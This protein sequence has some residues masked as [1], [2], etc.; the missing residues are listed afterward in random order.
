MNEKS[1]SEKP[2]RTP[3]PWTHRRLRAGD[4]LW[5]VNYAGQ[6]T[7]LSD[8]KNLVTV[9]VALD[10][11]PPLATLS[12]G[13]TINANTLR[14]FI[15]R[16]VVEDFGKVKLNP[17]DPPE[18]WATRQE[19][20][21]IQDPVRCW[22]TKADWQEHVRTQRAW[23]KLASRILQQ[24]PDDMDLFTVDDIEAAELALFGSIQE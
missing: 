13:A 24:S 7:V 22:L 18:K 3:S 21:T 14:G 11:D 1:Q 2:S 16:K 15:T 12:N 5:C 6:N 4:T 19:T 20:V 17:H 8:E 10:Y 23:N 9:E